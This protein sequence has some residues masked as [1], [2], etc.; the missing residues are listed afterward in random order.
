MLEFCSCFFYEN[1]FINDFF[2][3]FVFI[4]IFPFLEDT[5]IFSELWIKIIFWKRPRWKIGQSI[6]CCV[7]CV[8]FK[9]MWFYLQIFSFWWVYDHRLSLEW[10]R[11]IFLWWEVRFFWRFRLLVVLRTG[12]WVC[13]WL[14]FMGLGGK[15][16]SLFLLVII[17]AWTNLIE[18]NGFIGPAFYRR[19]L[20]TFGIVCLVDSF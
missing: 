12:F 7:K 11:V 17:F 10:R 4:I 5:R 18:T 15:I 19:K 9:S 20:L 6:L 16:V 1:V 3:I 2:I 13:I 8:V 14:V